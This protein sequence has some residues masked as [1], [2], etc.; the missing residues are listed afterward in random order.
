MRTYEMV[1][2]LRCDSTLQLKSLTGA[3]LNHHPLYHACDYF[4]PTAVIQMLPPSP[5]QLQQHGL[6]VAAYGSMQTTRRAFCSSS[7]LEL[8]VCIAGAG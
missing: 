5:N 6:V 8:L 7:K 2:D 4:I 3:K 1:C